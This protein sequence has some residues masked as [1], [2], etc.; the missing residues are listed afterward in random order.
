MLSK[1]IHNFCIVCHSKILRAG[2]YF[3][4]LSNFKITNTQIISKSQGSA[5]AIFP[6]PVLRTSKPEVSI[7]QKPAFHASMPPTAICN[8]LFQKPPH[9]IFQSRCFAPEYCLRRSQCFQKPALHAWILLTTVSMFSK[10]G[11]S[12]L[13]TA[14]DGL[15][16]FKAG[17][18]RIK[19]GF[20]IFPKAVLR[21]S[22]TG[23]F[24]FSKVSASHLN[25]AYGC[26]FFFQKAPIN[27]GIKIFKAGVSWLN[28]ASDG[29]NIFSRA[30]VSVCLWIDSLNGRHYQ[31]YVIFN[32]FSRKSIELTLAKICEFGIFSRT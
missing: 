2:P 7:F 17:A 4:R 26:F 18:S 24:N 15:N 5:L 6:K 8:I 20:W 16:V 29:F 31:K 19:N 10:A 22:K 13:N 30:G 11:A 14:Y 27:G 28:T 12:R 25:S 23:S 3:A 1:V 21:T 32:N 9:Q